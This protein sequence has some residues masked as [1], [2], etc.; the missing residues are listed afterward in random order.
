[1]SCSV[2][3][4]RRKHEYDY[5]KLVKVLVFIFGVYSVLDIVANLCFQFSTEQ[6]DV[7]EMDDAVIVMY[8]T[9]LA[10]RPFVYALLQKDIRKVVKQ[11]LCRRTTFVATADTSLA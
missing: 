7:E 6:C 11:F 8:L 2:N 4:N 5:A 1:M 9:N 3:V 10:L